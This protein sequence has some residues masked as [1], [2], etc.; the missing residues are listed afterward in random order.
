MNIFMDKYADQVTKIFNLVGTL[1]DEI[2]ELRDDVLQDE[3][4]TT[5][6]E[7]TADQINQIDLAIQSAIEVLEHIN[8]A[9]GDDEPERD[10]NEQDE[11]EEDED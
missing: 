11:D 9:A 3:E 1:H 5:T 10:E 8:H 7:A 6:S 4:S 2:H